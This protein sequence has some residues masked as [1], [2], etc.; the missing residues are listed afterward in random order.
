MRP[1]H[2]YGR[3]L[4]SV[5]RPFYST[6]AVSYRCSIRTESLSTFEIFGSNT[7]SLD[8]FDRFIS[9]ADQEIACT[10]Y[11]KQIMLSDIHHCMFLI[12]FINL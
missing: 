2:G 4:S 5:T 9:T 10:V 12:V 8:V 1:E 11:V 3:N 6:Y 7:P